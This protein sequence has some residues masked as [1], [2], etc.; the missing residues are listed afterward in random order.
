MNFFE[1]Q[2][3]LKTLTDDP[4]E[5]GITVYEAWE[6]YIQAWKEDRPG[7]VSSDQYGDEFVATPW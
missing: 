2:V 4:F 7:T 5:E 3:L 1:V 6:Q